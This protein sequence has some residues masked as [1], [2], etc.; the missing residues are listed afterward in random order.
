MTD[1]LG[2]QHAYICECGQLTTSPDACEACSAPEPEPRHEAQRLFS[3]APA[4][5]PGQ[6]GF[7]L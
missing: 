6:T 3:P 4:V 7:D 5:M 2:I 1:Y